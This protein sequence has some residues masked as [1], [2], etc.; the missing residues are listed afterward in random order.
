MNNTIEGLKKLAVILN[1]LFDK[2]DSIHSQIDDCYKPFN[3]IIEKVFIH[4]RE[5]GNGLYIDDMSFD[6]DGV[7]FD[8]RWREDDE[9]ES[10][11][12]YPIEAFIS[13][14]TLTK[15]LCDEQEKKAKAELAKK[16]H[17]ERMA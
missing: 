9:V 12:F 8:I 7:S 6:E 4:N 10:R 11:H 2:R 17:N 16:E 14:E 3:D 15:Y 5:Y 1:D 13:A